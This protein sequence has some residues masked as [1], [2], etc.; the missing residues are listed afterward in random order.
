VKRIGV[1]GAAGFVGSHLCDRLLAEGY[2]VVGIDDLSYGSMA[3]LHACL[4]HSSFQF[5][6][7]DCLHRR[8]LRSAFDGC[9]AIAHLAAKKIPRYHGAPRRSRTN[10]AGANAVFGTALAMGADLGRHLTSDVYGNGEPPYAEDDP[11]CSA[12]R[13]AAAGRTRPR[14]STTSTSPLALAEERGL[15]VTILRVQRLRPSQPP[16]LVGRP[17]GHVHRVPST[18]SRWR[19]TATACRPGRSPT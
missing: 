3:N 13:P 5:E 17:D 18:G 12:R 1:T 6:A 14:S 10:V 4:D 8:K 16:Q 9:D 15:K 19:S 11:S 2:E 7:L